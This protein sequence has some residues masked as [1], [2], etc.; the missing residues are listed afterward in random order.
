[1]TQLPTK[2]QKQILDFIATFTGGNGYGPSYREVM[3]GLGYKSV[4]TVAVHID[5]LMAKGYLRKGE[6]YS[7]RSLEITTPQQ[8]GENPV[9]EREKWLMKEIETRMRESN[10]DEVK[11]LVESLKILG[12]EEAYERMRRKLEL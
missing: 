2:K 7:A 9:D 4:S 1:M 12:F 8:S 6:G 11:I 3:Q 5:S 10:A